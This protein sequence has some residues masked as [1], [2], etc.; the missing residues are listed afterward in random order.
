MRPALGG[1]CVEQARETLPLEHHRKLPAKVVGVANAAVVAL[2]LPYGHDVRRVA[3]QQH[4]IHAERF[5]QPRVVRVDPLADVI[6]PV[7]MRDHLA[8]QRRHVL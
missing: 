6:D 2:T 5:R 1:V 8:N 3:R 4:A 7:R